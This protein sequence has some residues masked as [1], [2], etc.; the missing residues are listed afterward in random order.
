MLRTA[1]A[2]TSVIK[3]T[4]G[5]TV[6]L[7]NSKLPTL[8]MSNFE[9]STSLISLPQL[10]V[11][12]QLNIFDIFRHFGL[13]H[14]NAVAV[15]HGLNALAGGQA[16]GTELSLANGT[17]WFS[18]RYLYLIHSCHQHAILVFNT[19]TSP[20][21]NTCIEYI[22]VT[23]MQYLYWIHSCVGGQ[24]LIRSVCALQESLHELVSALT[25]DNLGQI[26]LYR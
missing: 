19:F 14:W 8:K 13:R 21:C 12:S 4:Q 24:C 7:P 26:N 9:S 22:H 2:E 6:F 20:A 23:N 1:A 15:F 10:G 16:P 18:W 25:L 17:F 3:R 5:A 11:G